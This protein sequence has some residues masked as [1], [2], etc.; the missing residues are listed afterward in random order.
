MLGLSDVLSSSGKEK[1]VLEK[2][3]SE[4]YRSKVDFQRMSAQKNVGKLVFLKLRLG[5]DAVQL[6]DVCILFLNRN[7]LKIIEM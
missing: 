1:A 3:V 4:I 2:V 5:D 6:G 7:K